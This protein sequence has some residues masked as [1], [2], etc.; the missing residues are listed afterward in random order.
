MLITSFY[1]LR[2][3]KLFLQPIVYNWNDYL[4][5]HLY[6]F[7]FHPQTVDDALKCL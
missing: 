4:T 3:Q 2:F 7:N 5:I 6:I 1:M